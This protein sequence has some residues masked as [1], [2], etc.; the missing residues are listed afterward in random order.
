MKAIF[1]NMI[2]LLDNEIGDRGQ[3]FRSVPI[4]R[5]RGNIAC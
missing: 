5:S 4:A 3:L 1:L 2:D